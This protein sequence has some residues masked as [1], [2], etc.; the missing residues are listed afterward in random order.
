MRPQINWHFATLGF[1]G[2]IFIGAVLSVA[3]QPKE[4]IGPDEVYR[5]LTSATNL[6][7]TQMDSIGSDARAIRYDVQAKSPT[8]RGRQR[9]REPKVLCP[10]I[11]PVRRYLPLE[12]ASRESTTS[13]RC[14]DYTA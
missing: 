10:L 11:T 6:L 5:A 9:Y 1:V 14:E 3:R 8:V 13:G 12:S 4:C 7:R 2:Q